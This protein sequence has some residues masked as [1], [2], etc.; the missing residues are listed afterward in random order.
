[1]KQFKKVEKHKKFAMYP[2][3]RIKRKIFK[4]EMLVSGLHSTADDRMSNPSG[5]S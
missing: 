5:R 1:M 3:P 2:P 4:N